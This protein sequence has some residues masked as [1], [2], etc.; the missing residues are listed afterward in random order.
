MNR[1]R[2]IFKLALISCLISILLFSCSSAADIERAN[3]DRAEVII[4]ALYE[5][6]Q[7]HYAFPYKLSTLVPD[8]LGKI[9]TQVGGKEF[10]Y[11]TD[12]VD[13]FN[14]GFEVKPHFGC[15]YTD[16]YKKWECSYGD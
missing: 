11:S 14:L 5:Y 4:N 1:K 9:P 3:K 13:G 10:F 2:N 8:D 6:K 7:A 15:G 16:K 12:S